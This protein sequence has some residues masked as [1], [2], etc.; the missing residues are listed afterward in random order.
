M[1]AIFRKEMADYFTSIRVLILFLL[2]L[3]ISGLA[4]FAAYKGIRG[5]G[6]EGFVFLRLFTTQIPD[7]PFAFLL[8]FGNFNALFLIPISWASML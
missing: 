3:F 6:S 7:F 2:T 5:T 4:L 8:T 1:K